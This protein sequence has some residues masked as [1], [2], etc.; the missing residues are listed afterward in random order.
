MNQLHR[1]EFLSLTAGAITATCLAPRAGGMEPLERKGKP[2]LKLSLAAYSFR[3]YLQAKPGT[4]GA[5]D[6][7]GFLD[8]CASLG[9]EGVELT[10]YYFP[11]KFDREYLFDLKR[12]AFLAGLD[13][14]GGAIGNDYC[15]PPGPKRDM[16]L[17]HTRQWVDHYADLG[18]P[19]IRVFAG[20][21]PKGEAEDAV[22]ARCIDTLEEACAIAGKRGVILALENHGGITEHADTMLK[23][24][25]GVKS[26]WFA[27]NLDSG[28]FRSN[29]DPYAELAKIAPYA[30]NAQIKLTMG[31]KGKSETADLSRTVGV[32]KDSGYSGWVVLEYEEP[33]DPYKSVPKYL[34]ELR[35][36]IKA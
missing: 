10:S 24:V 6:M 22:I 30:V 12:R 18:A 20:N 13:I 17:E 1:R 21:V 27:V 28:N 5:M 7:A 31:R 16:D 29:D 35:A 2:V 26:P 9:L 25:R 33:Q 3:Q 14:S 11:K 23:I 8:Y 19:V 4:N 32:L 15:Q 36:L 34:D